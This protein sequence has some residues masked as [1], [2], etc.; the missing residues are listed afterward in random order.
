LAGVCAEVCA[1][2][3]DD[4]DNKIP[5]GKRHERAEFRRHAIC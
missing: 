1:V 5:I 4:E 2:L 3:M